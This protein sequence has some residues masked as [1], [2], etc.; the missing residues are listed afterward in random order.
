MAS[1]AFISEGFQKFL[2]S[3]SLGVRQIIKIGISAPELMTPFV[4]IVEV[5]CGTMIFFL[6][7]HYL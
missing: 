5:A 7:L 6:L 3:E 2:F 1:I 4:R